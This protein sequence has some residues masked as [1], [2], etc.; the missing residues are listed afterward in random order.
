MKRRL[1]SAAASTGS[2]MVSTKRM[3]MFTSRIEQAVRG[4]DS[5]P[6][7]GDGN[8]GGVRI[9][10]GAAS[11]EEE[12]KVI[13]DQRLHLAGLGG[14][15]PVDGTAPLRHGAPHL[16]DM[17]TAITD[18]EMGALLRLCRYPEHMGGL[19]RAFTLADVVG[20]IRRTT[21]LSPA[22]AP[23]FLL[24]WTVIV[25][26]TLIRS[27]RT[28]G[29]FGGVNA[30]VHGDVDCFVR[31]LLDL[32]NA[33]DLRTPATPQPGSVVPHTPR[34]IKDIQ[35][36]VDREGLRKKT[37]RAIDAWNRLRL[38]SPTPTPAPKP[39]PVPGPV[40]VPVPIVPTAVPVPIVPTP[41]TNAT[42]ASSGPSVGLTIRIPRVGPRPT[43]G[44]PSLVI[45]PNTP[46]ETFRLIKNDLIADRFGGYH[47]D[48]TKYT[49]GR[50]CVAYPPRTGAT[51]TTFTTDLVTERGSGPADDER[52]P[53]RKVFVK[54][55]PRGGSHLRFK[56]EA[57]VAA[58]M[59]ILGL[60]P[61]FVA[62]LWNE[63]DPDA[64]PVIVTDFVG[65]ARTVFDLLLS[66]RS[67]VERERIVLDVHCWFCEVLHRRTHGLGI[68]FVHRDFHPQN[69]LKRENGS[70]LVVDFGGP[71]S[72]DPRVPTATY[73]RCGDVV[74]TRGIE[75]DWR[76]FMAAVHRIHRERPVPYH[77]PVP[78]AV[79][80]IDVSRVAAPEI[81]ASDY[82]DYIS[83]FAEPEEYP[84]DDLTLFAAPGD[85]GLDD[86]DDMLDAFA[87]Y[88]ADT[89]V[90]TDDAAESS[91]PPTR[92]APCTATVVAGTKADV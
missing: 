56:R 22:E 12:A 78:R 62:Y 64:M 43:P 57:L 5:T 87:R 16:C 81:D 17:H 29:G 23:R 53:P 13:R 48:P 75:D 4:L 79:E 55:M 11:R 6:V 61:M 32:M 59:G 14:P 31:I 9:I 68:H 60:A 84:D 15:G 20:M 30:D 91:V 33:A 49:I 8:T 72:A 44:V 66:A 51:T 2:V 28:I 73:S 21:D 82:A 65:D 27:F 1:D 39:R 63:T 45:D 25:L 7:P 35:C 90:A 42:D 69:I 47:L 40:P 37:D 36:L 38:A 70:Y 19:L 50:R 52:P 76:T 26:G 67:D 83:L 58:V 54:E 46:E 71:R 88:L 74:D 77:E 92:D 34:S 18:E 24:E 10:K 86:V 89:D 3:R 41:A 80:P 85:D